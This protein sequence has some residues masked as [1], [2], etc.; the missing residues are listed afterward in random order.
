MGSFEST[1]MAEIRQHAFRSG[2][3]PNN[4][5]TLVLAIQVELVCLKH[6]QKSLPL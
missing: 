6:D 2:P 1:I 4:Y 5:A 3:L